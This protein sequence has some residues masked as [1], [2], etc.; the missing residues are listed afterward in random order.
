MYKPCTYDQREKSSGEG[1]RAM[2]KQRRFTPLERK[3]IL[4]GFTLIELLVVIAIIALLMAILLP[5][6]RKARNQARA[7]VCQSN[8]KQWG[9]TLALY[10]EENK[11][12]LPPNHKGGFWLLRG[13]QLNEGDPNVPQIYHNLTTKG[14]SLCPMAA[15]VGNRN[16]TYISMLSDDED[17]IICTIGSRFTAW[18]ITKPSPPF[19]GSYGLN[20]SVFSGFLGVEPGR[21]HQ[22][23]LDRRLGVNIFTM[24]DRVS[25]P[26]LL[27]CGFPYGGVSV[28]SG[29]PKSEESGGNSFC[30]NRHD[31]F[32]N[33][34]FLNWSVRKV[35]LKE[36]W[37]LKWHENFDRKNK[38]TKAGG[39]QPDDWPEWMRGFKDY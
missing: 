35:G 4:T 18:E 24:K 1:D 22:S 17:K 14:I 33:G 15:K 6:L 23:L 3:K 36:L 9:A 11:G 38:W 21:D 10:A 34:L 13:P 2:E 28:R 8:L 12:R 26:I 31:G 30:I 5:S 37:K 27:D 32:V 19:R 16:S 39:V 25:F 29:P 20:Q 7:V